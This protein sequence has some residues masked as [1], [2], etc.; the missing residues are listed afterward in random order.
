VQEYQASLEPY[1]EPS[2]ATIFL[3][4]FGAVVMAPVVEELLFRGFFFTGFRSYLGPAV[5]AILSALL[6]SLAHAFPIFFPFA[7]ALHPTQALGA[8][9]GGLVFAGLRHDSDSI[10]PSMLAHAVWNL[11][12]IL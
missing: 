12:V 8:F 11:W 3:L 6:F 1:I 5:A 4:F 10:F 9:L 2:S 7:L